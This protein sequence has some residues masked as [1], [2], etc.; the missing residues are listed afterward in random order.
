MASIVLITVLSIINAFFVQKY[1]LLFPSY[2][3]IITEILCIIFAIM[4]FNKMLLYPTEI[5]IIKQS[6]FWFNTAVIIYQS[7]LFLNSAL[8]NYYAGHWPINLFIVKYFW[9]GTIFLF[10]FFLV[11]AILTDKKEI[12]ATNADVSY[13][14]SQ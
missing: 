13:T 10:Y 4:L 12:S 2:T 1:N 14:N 9:Y 7:S 8:A 3:M 6:T 5:N 11:I